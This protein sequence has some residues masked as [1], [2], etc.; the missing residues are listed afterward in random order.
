MI[1]VLIADDHAVVRRGLKQ[2][3]AEQRDMVVVG[4]AE[5]GEGLLAKAKGESWD[6][7]ILDLSLPGISGLDVLHELRRLYPRRAV[8]ILSVHDADQYGIRTLKAGAS[9]YLTKESAPEE[10]V[11]AIRKVIQGGRYV[12]PQLADKL[13]EYLADDQPA[14]RV[15]VLSDREFQIVT[16]LAHGKRVTEIADELSLSPKTISTY[17][18]RALEKLDLESNADLIQFA[19]QEGILGPDP[20]L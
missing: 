5:T 6:V 20:G 16:A 4:E 18:Q 9:G 10:L 7:A 2:I 14:S 13:V 19:L 15:D 1:R 3:I 12:N 11:N 8:L 17:R